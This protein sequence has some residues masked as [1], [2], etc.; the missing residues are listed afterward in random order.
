M[1]IATVVFSRQEIGLMKNEEYFGGISLVIS[2]NRNKFLVLI[3]VNFKTII[4][5][6]C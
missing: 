6:S 3:N 5:G 2:S 1:V 4:N